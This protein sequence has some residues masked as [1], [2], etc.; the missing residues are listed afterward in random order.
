MTLKLEP[1]T[2]YELPQGHIT[3]LGYVVRRMHKT[4]RLVVVSHELSAGHPAEALAET[5]LYAAAASASFGPAYYQPLFNGVGEMVSEADPAT[6]ARVIAKLEEQSPHLRIS[7]TVDMPDGNRLSGEESISGT[8]VSL[9]GLGMPA[10][11]RFNFVSA[12]GAYKAQVTG[13]VTSELLPGLLGNSR[14]RAHG[15]LDLRDNAGNTGTLRLNRGGEAHVTV[16]GRN[17]TVS[18]RREHLAAWPKDR[19]RPE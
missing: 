15:T 12:D 6:G 14:I 2:R 16:T 19:A 4:E 18:V 13:L 10:P 11:S 17:S 1:V 9:H 7:Y 5:A 3:L 8:T